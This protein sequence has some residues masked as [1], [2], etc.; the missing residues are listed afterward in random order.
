MIIFGAISNSWQCQL[1]TQSLATLVAEAQQRG[2]RH[3]ELRAT[4]LGDC[5]TGEGADWRPVL[6]NLQALV[7]AF[8]HLTFSTVV[9]C[10]L[11]LNGIAL[12]RICQPL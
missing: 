2:A 4:C 1:S 12:G 5:E 11:P 3:I 7:E 9:F 10:L 8:P 6:P